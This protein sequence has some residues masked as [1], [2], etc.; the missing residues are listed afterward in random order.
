MNFSLN[1]RQEQMQTSVDEF[2]S[3]KGGIELARRQMEGEYD[4][5]LEIWDEL[6]EKDYTALTVPFE[7]DGLGE[8]MLDLALFLEVAGRFALPGPIA[9]TL[10]VTVPLIDE[11]GT[12]D[13]RERYLPRIANGELCTTVALYDDPTESLPAAIT[14]DASS[15]DVGFRLSGTKMLVPYADVADQVLVAGRT[16]EGTGTEGI[17]LFM[18]DADLAE[19]TPLE[20]FDKT[21]PL[22]ELSFE[23]V[24]VGA[25]A[26]LGTLHDGGDALDRAFDNLNVARAAMLV[27][28]ADAAVDR[29]V[30]Y[31]NEREQFGHPIGRFQAVK[32]RIADMWLDLEASRSLTYYAAWALENNEPD[33]KRAVSEAACYTTEHCTDLF[34]DDIFNHGATGFTWEHDA[35]I[36]LKQAKTWENLLGSPEQHRENVAD[37]MF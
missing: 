22:Y 4:V 26:K 3:A 31:A 7:Y 2:L 21:R 37:A 8:G 35:H 30:N 15:T 10:G 36:F 23:G 17:T 25:D 6:A 12:E 28:G 1:S 13:Q 29:S 5:V 34:S 11:L 9:E 27:G 14:F 19:A 32:H 33:A 18:V 20:T 24:E 16:Q